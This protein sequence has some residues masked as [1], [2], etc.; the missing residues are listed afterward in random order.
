MHEAKRKT[1]NTCKKISP[2]YNTLE[3]ILSHSKYYLRRF[4]GDSSNSQSSDG[5]SS[6]IEVLLADRGVSPTDTVVMAL[7]TGGFGGD[8]GAAEGIAGEIAVVVAATVGGGGGGAS[9]G[10]GS[11]ALPAFFCESDSDAM[12][13]TEEAAEEVDDEAA[14]EVTTNVGG[15]VEEAYEDEEESIGDSGAVESEAEEE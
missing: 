4:F 11:M 2:V 3:I 13:V 10:G 12:I 7:C 14:G 1:K 5:P 6:S 8:A 9:L 15:A